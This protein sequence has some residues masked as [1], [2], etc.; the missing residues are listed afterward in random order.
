MPNIDLCFRSIGKTKS[1]ILWTGWYTFIVNE[2]L[3]KKTKSV[4]N[5]Q[6]SNSKFMLS[7]AICIVIYTQH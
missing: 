5:V 2:Q 7:V 6:I 1:K 4:D 3:I